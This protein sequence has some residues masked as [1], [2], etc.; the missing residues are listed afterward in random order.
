MDTNSALTGL[1]GIVSKGFDWGA[2]SQAA[3][4]SDLTLQGRI[5]QRRIKA[6]KELMR[7]AELQTL[8]NSLPEGTTVETLSQLVN[9]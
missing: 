5:D 2:L 4:A 1:S 7:V 9:L 8:L 3:A 6:E